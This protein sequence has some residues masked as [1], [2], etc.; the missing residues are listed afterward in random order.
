MYGGKC[1]RYRMHVQNEPKVKWSTFVIFQ[2][3]LCSFTKHLNTQVL[4]LQSVFSVGSVWP[5]LL[6]CLGRQLNVWLVCKHPSCL[7]TVVYT[8]VSYHCRSIKI[9]IQQVAAKC[10]S[11]SENTI[12]RNVWKGKLE[13]KHLVHEGKQLCIQTRQPAIWWTRRNGEQ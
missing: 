11:V 6:S 1:Y 10:F 5:Q 12:T 3:C 7:Q 2:D 13:H 4:I 9:S 8:Y